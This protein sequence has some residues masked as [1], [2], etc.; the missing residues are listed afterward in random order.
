MEALGEAERRFIRSWFRG[1][2]PRPHLGRDF[3]CPWRSFI[4]LDK[5]WRLWKLIG[6]ALTRRR[7]C[8]LS[9]AYYTGELG[10]PGAPHCLEKLFMDLDSPGNP[11]KARAEARKLVETLQGFCRPLVVYSGGK[12]Y[13]VYCYLPYCVEGDRDTLALLLEELHQLLGIPPLETLD[14]RVVYDPSRL[15]RIPYTLHEKTGKRVV[16]LDEDDFRPV[17]PDSISLE[18]YWSKP[19]QPSIV[20]EAWRRLRETPLKPRRRRRPRKQGLADATWMTFMEKPD[21]LRKALQGVSGE[22]RWR[23][24]EQLALYYRN[25]EML[26]EEE[27]LEKLLDWNRNNRPPLGE[28]E[29]RRIVS[30][31]YNPVGRHSPTLTG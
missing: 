28:D 20:E 8:F 21:L 23:L 2:Y 9:V 18:G 17:D 29:I 13:H 5:E 19:I 6:Y 7:P 24:A 27:C 11:D 3:G 25:V 4:P 14:T 10:R 31:V 22:L 16:V 30:K 15:S 12:G 1:A 26:G